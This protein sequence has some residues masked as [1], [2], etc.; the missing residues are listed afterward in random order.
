MSELKNG[1]YINE[2]YK[3][4]SDSLNIIVNKRSVIEGARGKAKAENIGKEIWKPIAYC[5]SFKHTLKFIVD[6]E[7][8][9]TGL[10]D[11]ETVV[12]KIDELHTMID[13]LNL[14]AFND[15]RE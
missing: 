14:E 4:T 9:G 10:V 11:L 2:D 12:A 13:K 5:S 3:I 1:L 6:N 8:M 15:T 7:I